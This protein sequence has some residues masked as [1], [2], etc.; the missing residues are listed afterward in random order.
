MTSLDVLAD[1]G[2]RVAVEVADAALVVALTAVP[3]TS[4]PT[5]VSAGSVSLPRPLY[6]ILF[7]HFEVRPPEVG[8]RVPEP[9]VLR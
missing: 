4:K 7:Q 2:E 1:L 3:A 5:P 6:S 9:R 8:G